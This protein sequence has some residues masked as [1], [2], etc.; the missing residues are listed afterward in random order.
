[1]TQAHTKGN[2]VKTVRQQPPTNPGGNYQKKL[3]PFT[4]SSQA[5]GFQNIELLLFKVTSQCYL[6]TTVLAYSPR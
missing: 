4:S 2:H 5:P 3:H 6:I 1:M